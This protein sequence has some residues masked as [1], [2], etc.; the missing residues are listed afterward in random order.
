MKVEE[1]KRKA[2]ETLEKNFGVRNPGQSEEVKRKMKAT[3]LERYGVEYVFQDSEF[4]RK[5]KETSNVIYG[6]DHASKTPE[7]RA[8]FRLL[9]K[10]P[11]FI[12]KA[13]DA[14]VRKYGHHSAWGV[15][16]LRT[17][18]ESKEA[19]AI[20]HETMKKNGTYGKSSGENELYLI[21]K[22]AFPE[23][24]RQEKV[25]SWAIDFYVPEIDAYVNYNGDYWHG[26]GKPYELLSSSANPRDAVILETKRR[27]EERRNWFLSQ[28]LNFY[29]VWEGDFK[30]EGSK[31]LP[32][33]LGR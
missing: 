10:N 15:R 13:R 14:M 1:V 28:G 33:L 12:Q 24:R 23:T 22:A 7:R 16:E 11:E 5:T 17:K 20:R 26:R 4:K 6:V 21:L 2:A 31:T 8:Q 29:E 32:F 18:I 30:K 25:E 19:Q 3:C 9:R 27:D